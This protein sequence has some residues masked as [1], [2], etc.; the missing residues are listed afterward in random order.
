MKGKNWLLALNLSTSFFLIFVVLRVVITLLTSDYNWD[1]DHEMYFG[2]RLIEGEL[3]YTKEY[4][5]KLPI[6]QYLFWAPAIAG[7]IRLWMILSASLC[8]I[9]ALV[10]KRF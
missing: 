3:I 9:A 2:S 7:S 1:L 4:N 8:V 10:L 6:V 5:D